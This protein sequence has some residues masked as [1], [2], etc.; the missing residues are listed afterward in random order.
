VTSPST[1][2]SGGTGASTT[3]S[4]TGS[5]TA[6]GTQT[7][8]PNILGGGTSGQESSQPYDVGP[9][10]SLGLGGIMTCF[11]PAPGGLPGSFACY[12]AQQTGQGGMGMGGMGMGGMGMG[13]MGWHPHMSQMRKGGWG[14]EQPNW[15]YEGRESDRRKQDY[16]RRPREDDGSRGYD[17]QGQYDSN[18]GYD[19]RYDDSRQQQ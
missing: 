15:Y 9:F 6:P 19:S 7:E 8:N 18:Q 2:T 12:P 13:G 11:T 14:A 4:G 16:D 10:A 5:G 17:S 1:T 3:S